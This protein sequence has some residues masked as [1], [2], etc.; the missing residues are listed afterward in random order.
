MDRIEDIK[1]RIK[2]L[3]KLDLTSKIHQFKISWRPSNFSYSSIRVLDVD[4]CLMIPY[5]DLSQWYLKT[6]RMHLI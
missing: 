3:P 4:S 1:S 2:M 6:K 5:I